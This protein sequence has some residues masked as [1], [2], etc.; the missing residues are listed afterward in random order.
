MAKVAGNLILH[1]ASGSLGDQI[2]IRQRGGQTILSASPTAPKGEPTEAQL[3]H[4]KRFQQAVLY[5][6][7]LNPANK[8]EYAAK[9]DGLLSA[10]NVAV[11]DFFHAPDIDEIDVT[12]YSGAIGERIRI[13]AI[14]DFKVK[15]VNV[16]IYNA[17]GSL[18]EQGD[19]VQAENVIDWNYTATALNASLE[20]DKIII[21]VSDNPG[22]VTEAEEAL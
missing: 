18:V 2:V 20:G 6:K 10:Y 14:D 8:A 3:A 4:R 22:N 16:A 7:N 17:D 12:H 11:A 9:A 15:Q 13:R 5:G 19:A 1:G 21:K